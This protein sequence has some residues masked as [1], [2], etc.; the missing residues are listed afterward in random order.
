MKKIY[1]AVAL[2]VVAAL[3]ICCGG[4]KKE[5]KKTSKPRHTMEASNES[6][7]YKRNTFGENNK[8]GGNEESE[9]DTVEG[10]IV[11]Y[12]EDDFDATG[13]IIE[14][15]EG[16]IDSSDIKDA[17]S[18]YGSQDSMS[19][20]GYYIQLE[21]TD[22]GSQKFAAATAA[23]VGKRIYMTV[24]GEIISAPTVQSGINDIFCIITGDFTKEEAQSLA[25]SI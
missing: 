13:N 22:E 19:E 21:F 15:A 24:N 4:C 18:Q 20:P 12:T 16:V 17:S 14:G 9:P 2:A 1:A 25:D 6:E 8:D 11:F 3:V 7:S 23:N 5:E 10:N